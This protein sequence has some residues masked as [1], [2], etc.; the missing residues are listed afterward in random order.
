MLFYY[1][2]YTLLMNDDI[3]TV[4]CSLEDHEIKCFAKIKGEHR[5]RCFRFK[6]RDKEGRDAEPVC[7][8]SRAA[9]FPITSSSFFFWLFSLLI[10]N[11][12]LKLRHFLK[13]IFYIKD[14]YIKHHNFSKFFSLYIFLKN[15]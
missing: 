15:I 13:S 10:S 6:F 9:P 2:G 5:W 4:F 14:C 8:M 3:A 12:L 11:F 7:V 1:N